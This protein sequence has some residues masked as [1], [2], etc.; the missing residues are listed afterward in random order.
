MA[1]NAGRKHVIARNLASDQIE[2]RLCPRAF[3]KM[4]T[5]VL[6]TGTGSQDQMTA[7]FHIAFPTLDQF[8]TYELISRSNNERDSC[9]I[10]S[11]L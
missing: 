7:I 10:L 2:Y 9:R 1:V 3:P 8:V 11:P 6:L 5:H 4:P